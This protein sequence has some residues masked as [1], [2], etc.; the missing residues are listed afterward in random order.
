MAGVFGNFNPPRQKAHNN[1][2]TMV[3]ET[4]VGGDDADFDECLNLNCDEGEQSV[5]LKEYCE[6]EDLLDANDD[7]TKAAVQGND[8]LQSLTI[9]AEN[10]SHF[11]RKEPVANDI[12]TTKVASDVSPV[13]ASANT[14]TG[15]DDKDTQKGKLH[16]SV[17]QSH[18]LIDNSSLKQ[19]RSLLDEI[20]PDERLG[21]KN[22]LQDFNNS[23]DWKTGHVET[24]DRHEANTLEN[25]P[26][27]NAKGTKGQEHSH[28]RNTA[29]MT[30][31]E[32][33]QSGQDDHFTD[34]LKETK[35]VRVESQEPFPNHGGVDGE[36][37]RGPIACERSHSQNISDPMDVSLVCETPKSTDTMVTPMLRGIIDTRSDQLL[38]PQNEDGG[39]NA[40]T[41]SEK[42]N[43]KH[44]TV[45]HNRN[46]RGIVPNNNPIANANLLSPSRVS[47][48][49]KCNLRNKESAVSNVQNEK[50]LMT[51]Q[52]SSK[53]SEQESPWVRAGISFE[54]WMT[55]DK[56]KFD[57]ERNRLKLLTNG[58]D[59]LHDK[60]STCYDNLS[61]LRVRV[62]A[63]SNKVNII[64][65]NSR[66]HKNI[67][68]AK[69]V[70]DKVEAATSTS[71]DPIVTDRSLKRI[72]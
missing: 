36:A 43:D 64:C 34:E 11:E 58:V 65:N 30:G 15:N 33:N 6:S 4:M 19:N 39:H 10:E 45:F 72:E 52:T 66:L 56:R 20:E 51:P 63:Y 28:S 47:Q 55:D 40:E 25:A 67:Q 46:Q 14:T 18:L 38:T 13:V 9:D 7:T 60:M 62:A 1:S 8:K 44:Q 41:Y 42:T 70:Y 54:Q 29:D 16:A 22:L 3:D 59:R 50:G 27:D 37:A 5:V 17:G 61:E 23:K 21:P 31:L 2:N 68:Y 26:D 24:S 35:I 48:I 49:Q 53:I 57:R 69:Q 12:L 71:Y 32:P